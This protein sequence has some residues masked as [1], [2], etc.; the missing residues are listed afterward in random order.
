MNISL[1]W[2]NAYLDH[3][4]DA[5][6][7][8]RVLTDL[9][10]PIEGLEEHSGDTVLDVEVT[11]NR[12]DCLSHIGVARELAAGTGRELQ[13][14]AIDLHEP[15][16]ADPVDPVERLTSVA[17][18]AEDLCPVYTARVIRG[19]K[20]GR[21]P[22]WLV[23]RLEAI[24]LRS[25]N[26]V[27]D[28]TNYVLMEMGQPLHVFDLAR[29]AERRIV[30]RRA[31]P[32]E[33]F[34]AIDG[35]KHGLDESMLVI[36]DAERPV[37]VAGVMGGLESE[38][39]EQTVDVLLESAR[40]DPLSV[41]TTSRALKL[42]SDSSYRFERGV[43]PK[44]VERASRR[45]AALIVELAGGEPAKGVIRVGE[46]EPEPRTVDL[47][48]ERA[49]RLL[50]CEI[51]TADM[52]KHLAA[53]ELKPQQSNGD[54]RC[55]IPSHRLDLER[56]ADLIEEVARVHG[57]DEIPMDS[58]MRFRIRP[59]QDRVE[60]RKRLGRVLTAHG[61]HETITFTFLAVERGA[62]FLPRN[63]APVTID[64]EVRRAEP[65]LRPALIPSL[66]TVRKTNQDAGNS[67]L[68]LFETGS[69]CWEEAHQIM[70]RRRLG[71]LMDLPEKAADLHDL[72]GTIEEL[73]EQL[74]GREATF[75]PVDDARFDAAAEVSLDGQPLGRMGKLAAKLVDQFDLQTAVAAADL[76]LD[77]LLAAYPPT[78]T[79][80]TLPK[81]PAIERDLSVIV[82]E[83]TSWSSVEKVIERAGP[84]LLERVRF[85]DTYRGKQVGAGRKSVT[86]RL[87]FRDPDKTLRHDE[88]DPQ[89]SRVVEQLRKDLDA[90]LRS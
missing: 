5:D 79:V 20:V 90:E 64:D 8:E 67:R 27:V 44:G 74:T 14:P 43:D 58:A 24:G 54:I 38:V 57:Y 47:R 23:R 11:S 10:F 56:E 16:D 62:P 86:F 46:A 17:N 40:F 60:A 3:P 37:A 28:V 72:R 34:T 52:V 53:L 78:P 19:V 87:L 66:L 35:S 82:A 59:P 48:P 31:A 25:V 80:T 32:K 70:E 51:A 36:A 45:A 41:R 30:V 76:E 61:Y 6:E 15:G 73:V 4:T 13:L 88:V 39:G 2:L 22:D 42:S 21:S 65:M 29:L 77:P 33:P 84:E 69:V 26:N 89:V 1:E 71:L 49:C 68:R 81:Y 63:T 83:Q 55:A 12:G 85:V 7:A 50:G 9:G 75:T 18:E